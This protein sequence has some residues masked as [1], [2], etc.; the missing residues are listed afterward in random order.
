MEIDLEI[1]K[2]RPTH[3]CPYLGTLEY[4]SKHQQSGDA[5]LASVIKIEFIQIFKVKLI[6]KLT[7]YCFYIFV[8]NTHIDKENK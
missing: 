1:E 6:S 8:T 7:K 4:I 3:Q 5:H 2:N